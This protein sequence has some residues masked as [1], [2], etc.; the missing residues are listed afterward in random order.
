[1]KQPGIVIRPLAMASC[2]LPVSFDR[3]RLEAAAELGQLPRMSGGM[4]GT[5]P[6]SAAL[7]A[8]ALAVAAHVDPV[9][10]LL[11]VEPVVAELEIAT[12]LPLAVGAAGWLGTS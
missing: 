2:A 9:G 12:D 7:A 6:V 5:I 1:M 10:R 8:Q 11:G 3:I 4:I